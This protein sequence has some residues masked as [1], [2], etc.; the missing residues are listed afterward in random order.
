MT[1]A[2]RLRLG[3]TRPDVAPALYR[4]LAEAALSRAALD[5]C[6]L[7]V[8]LA[9][10][11]GSRPLSYVNQAFEALFG[12]RAAEALGRPAVTLL[13]MDPACA[14]RLFCEPAPSVVLSAQRKDSS[15]AHVEVTVGAVRGSDGRVT[16]WVLAFCDRTEL[17]ELRERLNRPST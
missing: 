17:L 1:V 8:A 4:L 15:L 9:D 10:A 14:E 3:T 7:P 5:A 11:T 13:A 16:H 2:E 12:Y 6:G